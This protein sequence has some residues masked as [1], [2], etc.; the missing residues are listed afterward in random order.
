L[1]ENAIEHTGVEPTLAVR[2]EPRPDSGSVVITVAD[3]GPGIPDDEQAVVDGRQSITPLDHGSGLGLWLAKW[4]AEAYGGG[5]AFVGPDP[6][7]GGAAVEL[8]FRQAD[9]SSTDSTRA[10][11]A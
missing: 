3:D 8:R 10:D 5:L 1:V 2:V 11:A 9:P 6:T 4:I 7:L